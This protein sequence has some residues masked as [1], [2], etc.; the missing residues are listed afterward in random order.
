MIQVLSNDTIQKIAAGEVIE[1]PSSIVK[2]LVENSIDAGATNIVVEIKNGG[3]DYIEV[4]DNGKGIAKDEIEIA[5]K[6]HATSKLNDFNDLYNLQ[7]L[8]F[9]GEALASIVSVSKVIISTR[10]NDEK[11]GHKVYFEDGKKIEERPIAKNIGTSIIVKDLF[12]NV[13]VRKR[14]LKSKTTEANSITNLMYKLAIGN[15]G[16][17]IT[18]IKDDKLIFETKEK[19]NLNSVLTE[20]FGVNIVDNLLEF[21]L[22]GREYKINGYISNNKYYRANRSLQY[23][24]I[25]GRYIESKEIRDSI[26]TAYKAVIPNGRYPVFQIFLSINPKH[27]DVNIH[28]NKEKVQITI[29]EEILN[30]IQLKTKEILNQEFSLPEIK[31]KDDIKENILFQ[32]DNSIKDLLEKFENNKATNSISNT[33]TDKIEKIEHD[34]TGKINLDNNTTSE[35]DFNNFVFESNEYYSVNTNTQEDLEIKEDYNIE[36]E[37]VNFIKENDFNEYI[38]IGT[39]F[40]TYLLYEDRVN[41]RIFIV[42]QHAAHERVLYEEFL[43]EFEEDEVIIQELIVPITIDLKQDEY[44]LYLENKDI[45]GKIGYNVDL[46]GGRTIIIRSVPNILGNAKNEQLFLDLL[47]SISNSDKKDGLDSIYKKIIKNSCKNAVKAGDSLSEME[48][49][50][51][52]NKL[53]NCKEPYTCPHGRPTLIEMSKYELEKEFMR[54]K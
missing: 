23:I 15:Y 36:I 27:I 49:R 44:D 5:F 28:P 48:I 54:V 17:G 39:I 43:K 34:N 12:Y 52:L 51:L 37:E 46:F 29:L 20:L 42:D 53:M 16:I 30:S 8:G 38:Y 4:L 25:N 33:N 32:E 26:E 31:S 50:E 9:R 24:Y 2:E 6:R 10:T 45:F 22:S 19:E 18:Y 1:K 41:N 7:S 13:P 21:T 47:D 11:L 35:E 3:L 14:F 40:K